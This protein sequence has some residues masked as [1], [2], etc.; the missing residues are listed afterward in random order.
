MPGADVHNARRGVLQRIAKIFVVKS[1]LDGQEIHVRAVSHYVNQKQPRIGQDIL[2]G[3][4]PNEP[5]RNGDQL[6]MARCL[7]FGR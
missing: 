5:P 6:G 7:G 2:G 3:F 4:I 1:P